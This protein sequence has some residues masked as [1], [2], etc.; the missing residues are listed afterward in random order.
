MNIQKAECRVLAR[1]H[2]TEAPNMNLRSRFHIQKHPT[3]RIFIIHYPSSIIHHQLK[4]ATPKGSRLVSASVAYSGSA[5]GFTNK[6][7][8]SSP[9]IVVRMCGK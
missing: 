4:K 6:P 9:Y 5:A 7:F 2:M 3:P 8:S 1:L